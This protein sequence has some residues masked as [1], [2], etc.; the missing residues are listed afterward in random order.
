[1][2]RAIATSSILLFRLVPF[3]LSASFSS[4]KVISLEETVGAAVGASG[5]C[6]DDSND[7]MSNK[8]W[9]EGLADRDEQVEL[10]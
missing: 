1:M 7:G 9:R 2:F 10:G 5:D 4:N 6:I 8:V 3:W